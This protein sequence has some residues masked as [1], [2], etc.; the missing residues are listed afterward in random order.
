MADTCPECFMLFDHCQCVFDPH[1]GR[2]SGNGTT[3][4]VNIT[5]DSNDTQHENVEFSDQMSPYL[6]DIDGTIDPTRR[7]Q[8]SNDATL[9]NF[10]SRPIKIH[11]EEWGTG[12]V[13]SFAI[14]PWSLFW[15]NK[16]VINRISNFNL[17]KADLKIK[18]I[19]NGNGFHYGRAVCAY[20][21]LAQFDQVSN[22]TP[23]LTADFIN[24]TQLPHIYLDPTTSN[25]GEMKL[26]MF[27]HNNSLNVPRA[28]WSEMG[29]LYFRS[30]NNLK[31]ANGA[32][33]QVTISVFAWAENVDMSVLT[34]TEPGTLVPQSGRESSEIDTANKEGVVSGPATKLA[35]WA[36]Y[37]TKV[38]YIGPFATATQIGAD[39]TSKIAMMFGFCRPPVTR[40]PEPYR[41]TPFSSLA[42]TN[43]PDTAHKLTV[44]HK[45][46]LTIDP[47]IAGIGGVDSLNIREIAKRESFL[48]Q[49]PWAI[50]TPPETLLWNSR[51]TPVIWNQTGTGRL[52]AFH[53]P[54]CAFAAM[55]FKYWTGTMRFRFQIVASSFHK[56]RIKVVYDPLYFQE[57]EYNTNY[58]KIIDIAEEQDFTVE[59]GVG[60]ERNLMTHHLPGTN[61]VSEVFDTTAFPFPDPSSHGNGTISL[62][63]VNELTTPNSDT[64]NNIEVNVFVSMGDDFEVF[65]PTE[66]INQFT[67]TPTS[68]IYFEEAL[69]AQSGMEI[70]PD[71][72]DTEEPSAPQQ[73]NATQ[74]G[75]GSSQLPEINH[76]FTGES[77]TSFRTMLKRY[78]FWTTLGA[79]ADAQILYGRLPHFPYFRGTAPG[80]VNAAKGGTLPYNYCNTVLL[81]WV[82]LAYSG[83]RGSIRYKFIPRGCPM[84]RGRVEVQRSPLEPQ[85]NTYFIGVEPF[86]EYSNP[87]Q[88]AASS[89]YPTFTPLFQSEKPFRGL[90][91]QSLTMDSINGSLEV[92]IPYY[93][94]YR[95][96]PGKDI[97]AATSQ[98]FDAPWDYRIE[99]CTDGLSGAST[100]GHDLHV[101]IGE[102]FQTF[103][104][105][106]LPRMYFN[107]EVP[108]VF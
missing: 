85:G 106:G 33:D 105:T 104:Y 107:A 95:F 32:T 1:S 2:E 14:N 65:A 75:M 90:L 76:V 22:F 86:P 88:A 68:D 82:R 42:L 89:L 59:F 80:A 24:L 52:S 20:L 15:N 12:T 79:G 9:Q 51:V 35:K 69:E 66:Y 54:P 55:P 16:R 28:Q 7:L 31:H 18:V 48:T 21:P 96:S 44:D 38:P 91:G 19:I 63:V 73:E 81:H 87:D 30:M 99:R 100:V 8:D 58:T 61:S 40:N 70:V 41:P 11:E 102:D 98:T 72:Q 39:A 74:V 27:Y 101:A 4:D 67:P 71:S 36:S 84:N 13:L 83:W 3:N 45:Q 17:L 62:Y 60:Q 50:G 43:V 23:F 5:K 77:I 29:D 92:E 49:F 64:N 6:Y 97:T 93:S 57:N 103:F 56:G 26:P 37:L 108:S 46:E 34:S 25:G 53:F 47:R 94:N 78:N 10:F